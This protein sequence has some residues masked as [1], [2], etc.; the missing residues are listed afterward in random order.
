MIETTAGP[1]LTAEEQKDAIRKRRDEIDAAF[2]TLWDERNRLAAKMGV[3]QREDGEPVY[4][5]GD[6]L[7]VRGRFGELCQAHGIPRALGQIVI[8]TV[9]ATGYEAQRDVLQTNPPEIAGQ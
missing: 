5:H 8:G 9:V 2:V 4:N 1:E 6:D 7:K 3:M